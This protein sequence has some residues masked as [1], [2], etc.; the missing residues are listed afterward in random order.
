MKDEKNR[1]RRRFLKTVGQAVGGLS[2]GALLGSVPSQSA[3]KHLNSNMSLV[4]KGDK[5]Y[6]R[7]RKNTVWNQRKPDLYPD[8]IIFPYTDKDI[9]DAVNHARKNGL[10]VA[11]RS[12]GHNW[13][14][15]HVRD[16]GLLIDLSRIHDMTISPD[17]GRATIRPAV[18]ARDLQTLLNSHG[19][20]FPTATCPTV[21]MGGFLLGGGASFTTRLDGA[22]CFGVEAADVVLANG[23]L[24]HATDETHPEIMWAVRGSGPMFFGLV[25]RFYL[26]VKPLPKSMLAGVY[27][28]PSTVSKEFMKW[29]LSISPSLP[30]GIQH[31]WFGMKSQ[32]PQYPGET[33]MVLMTGLGDSD[34]EVRAKMAVFDECPV[35]DRAL[36]TVPPHPWNY[37]E[38]YSQVDLLYPK[39]YRFRSDA[40]WI[41]EPMADGFVDLVADILETMP[42]SHS[43]LLWAPYYS[44]HI[45]SNSCYQLDPTPPLS[46]H[47]YGVGEKAEDDKMLDDW[48]NGW[49]R[50]IQKYSLFGG[51]GKI[52]DN[53]LLQ[54][55]KYIVSPEN[56]DRLEVLQQKYDPLG[57]FH[58]QMGG[59]RPN[60]TIT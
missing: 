8:G 2:V 56:T 4:K 14:G 26:K 18:R 12:G 34:D 43:H 48:V 22:S 16:N 11:V 30:T 28:F 38:G 46:L 21:G 54:F 49:L 55:P 6:E 39:G 33:I 37:D 10:Q 7:F 23:E 57:V 13:I 59:M 53:N 41:E 58:R 29:H 17:D 20:R 3:N 24:I 32:A 27:A 40:L 47:I 31:G 5:D 35:L 60:P 9:V 42:T 19:Y 25:T 15:N 44:G 1:E 50:E 45:E 51:S 36:F 52:N